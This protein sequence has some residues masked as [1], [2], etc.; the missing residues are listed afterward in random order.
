MP[1]TLNSG[2]GISIV[3]TNITTNGVD[4]DAVSS[5]QSNLNLFFTIRFDPNQVFN[6]QNAFAANFQIEN[7]ETGQKTNNYWRDP[8]TAIAQEELV[9]VL[10]G[11]TA[12]ARGASTFGVGT[13]MVNEGRKT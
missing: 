3:Q 12:A 8:L 10:L 2:T 7:C 9:W 5:P 4:R 1:P 6:R 13:V 11:G